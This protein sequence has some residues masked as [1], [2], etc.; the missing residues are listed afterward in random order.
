M[1]GDADPAS[2]W[3]FDVNLF[4]PGEPGRSPHWQSSDGPKNTY[5][6]KWSVRFSERVQSWGV[7]PMV[8]LVALVESCENSLQGSVPFWEGAVRVYKDAACTEA[9]GYGFVEQMGY[10]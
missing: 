5:G 2:P 4:D 9:I 3:D 10:N 6:T 8:Y 1:G 7:P